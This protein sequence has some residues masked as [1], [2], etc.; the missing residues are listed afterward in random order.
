MKNN[1]LLQNYKEI[2]E[3]KFIAVNIED[4]II[5]DFDVSLNRMYREIPKSIREKTFFYLV[6]DKEFQFIKTYE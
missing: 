2:Y 4:G 5:F 6:K 3:N 1:K